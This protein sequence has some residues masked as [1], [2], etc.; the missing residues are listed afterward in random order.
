LELVD[1]AV[2]VPTDDYGVVETVH[3]ALD[4]VLTECLGRLIAASEIRSGAT[5]SVATGS[6]W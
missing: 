4:H 1:T 6:T 2:I 3:L 5:G